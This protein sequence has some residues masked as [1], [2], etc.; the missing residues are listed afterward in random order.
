VCG[1]Q[2]FQRAIP[3]VLNEQTERSAE[4][5]DVQCDSETSDAEDRVEAS[6][7]AQRAAAGSEKTAPLKGLS[8]VNATIATEASGV[9]SATAA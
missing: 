4:Q 2:L 8:K 6:C 1:A 9:L 5:E 3:A 7:E